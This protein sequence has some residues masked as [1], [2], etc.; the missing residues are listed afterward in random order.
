[1]KYLPE[2]V[3]LVF[4]DRDL[5]VVEKPAGLLTMATE[6]EKRRT[7]YSILFDELKR[8]RPPQRLFIVH[9][10][11]REASGLLVFAKSEEAKRRLQAQFEDH[12]AGRTY[13]A[14]TDGRIADDSL[15][16]R[17]YLAENAIHRCYSTPDPARGKLAVTHVTVLNRG[18][19]YTRVEVRL[20]SGRKHQIRVHLAERGHPLA[21]DPLYGGKANPIR[22]LALHG[23]R[24]TFRHPFTNRPMEFESPP[25][26]SFSRLA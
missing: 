4:E 2:G 20:E 19:K 8:R 23:V 7:V 16:L 9:R 17:S 10:L 11:D 12:S 1:M 15:T 3:T 22:R 5:L 21:G 14:V 26:A 24:L 25:P 18:T 13:V 6:T